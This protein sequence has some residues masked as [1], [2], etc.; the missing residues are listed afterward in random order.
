MNFPVYI[1]K[2]YLRSK[3]SQNAVNIINF[4][5]FLVIVIGSAALFIVLSA[6]TGLKSFS[7][8]FT[9]SFDP[10]I[11]AIPTTGKFFELSKEKEDQLKQLS[12]VAYYSKE[13]EERVYLTFKDK[14]H[15]A[16]LKGIDEQAK[17]TVGLDS[18]L[19]FGEW[20]TEGFSSVVGIGI[21]NI[22]GVPI[23]NFQ[24]PMVALAPKPGKG[25]INQQVFQAKPYNSLSLVV[26]GVFSAEEEADRSYVFASLPVVQQLL[27][28]NTSTFSSLSFK[29]TDKINVEAAKQEL[30]PILGNDVKLLSKQE[31]NST[32][33]KMLN[34][35]NVATYL[36]FTL[37]LIIALFNVVGA[38]IMM[39]LDKQKILERS[40]L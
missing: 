23:N 3:S 10:D 34:T 11:K 19:Y 28:K 30:S 38:I 6:F 2:R 12:T 9:T 7:L 33:Y 27:E 36:V 20:N 35:E 40:M 29:L 26:S 25:S 17:N 15:L 18:S 39:I 13:I 8:Q 16:I 32:L 14:S 22:L 21:F 37:V 5:T 24:S 4:I 1:A 31:Q